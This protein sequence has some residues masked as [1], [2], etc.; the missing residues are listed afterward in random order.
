MVIKGMVMVKKLFFIVVFIIG[1]LAVSTAVFGQ[2][3]PRLGILPFTGGVGGDGE[4]IATLFSFQP[5][6]LNAFTV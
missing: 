4:S 1:S 2:A 6:I 5:D 3:K